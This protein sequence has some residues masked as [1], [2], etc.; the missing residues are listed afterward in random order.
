MQFL[1]LQEASQLRFVSE[2]NY[3]NQFGKKM[4]VKKAVKRAK[5][6]RISQLTIKAEVKSTRG[7]QEETMTAVH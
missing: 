5:S 7:L 2:D 6:E 4:S 1:K 3:R